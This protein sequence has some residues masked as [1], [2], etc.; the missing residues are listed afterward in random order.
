MPKFQN[1]SKLTT[2]TILCALGV[3][4]TALQSRA[5][6]PDSTELKTAQLKNEIL[7]TQLEYYKQLLPTTEGFDV[8]KGSVTYPESSAVEGIHIASAQ[9]RAIADTVVTLALNHVSHGQQAPQSAK[10]MKAELLFLNDEDAA[11]L[12][13]YYATIERCSYF[14]QR[15]AFFRKHA[16]EPEYS[17]LIAPAVVGAL[18]DLG[19]TVVKLLRADVVNASHSMQL[20]ERLLRAAVVQKAIQMKVKVFDPSWD[21]QQPKESSRLL[22]KLSALR[23]AF[24]DAESS[25]LKGSPKNA[26]RKKQRTDLASLKKEFAAFEGQLYASTADKPV[27]LLTTLL[28]SEALSES[29]VDA[30]IVVIRIERVS[31]A[32]ESKSNSITSSTRMAAQVLATCTL[33][34]HTGQVLEA[35]FIEKSSDY[36]KAGDWLR[37]N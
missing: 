7:K 25:L 21:L 20:D 13:A 6:E 19:A 15:I 9:I 35:A 24:E 8:K 29:L 31:V 1:L 32:A 12:R 14:Q 37:R 23:T 5:V 26:E 11:G 28:L 2:I 36:R 27:S 33:L 34:D 16:A 18:V 10:P 30:C 17:T 22:G 3:G 4:F